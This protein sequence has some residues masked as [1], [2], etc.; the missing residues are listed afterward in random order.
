MPDSRSLNWHNPRFL[1]LNMVNNVSSPLPL[2]LFPLI[3]IIHLESWNACISLIVYHRRLL[4]SLSYRSDV[5]DWS[6]VCDS[7]DVCDWSDVCD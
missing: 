1:V 2:P 6:D 5:C 4:P 7:S 3:G